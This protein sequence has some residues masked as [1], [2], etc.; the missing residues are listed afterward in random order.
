MTVQANERPGVR[1]SSVRV[2]SA[3]LYT[4]RQYRRTNVMSARSSEYPGGRLYSVQISSARL[5]TTRQYGRTNVMS[6]RSSEHVLY[7]CT[8]DG[9]T[10]YRCT[11]DRTVRRTLC[12]HAQ[13]NMP[14]VRMSRLSEQS[15][16]NY[17]RTTMPGVHMSPGQNSQTT[18]MTAHSSEHSRCTYV[19]TC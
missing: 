12:P 14:G 3:R 17:D 19:P 13:T 10:V 9:C 16:D 7:I 2:F 8:L 15:D 4:T 11:L 6:A 18:I 5:Y 1:L